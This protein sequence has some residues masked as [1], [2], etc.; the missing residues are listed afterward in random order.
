MTSFGKNPPGH[1]H[2]PPQTGPEVEIIINNAPF[3]IHRGRQSVATIKQVGG[4][5]SADDLEQVV[6]GQLTPLADDGSVTI[7]GG[8]VFLSHIKDCGSS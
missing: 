5:P 1:D 4:V 7:K 8:E 6:N 3:T 2:E